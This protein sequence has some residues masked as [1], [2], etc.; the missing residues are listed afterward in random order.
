MRHAP[1]VEVSPDDRRQLRAW[2]GAEAPRGRLAV[3]AQIVLDAAEGLP[4]ARIAA[5]LGVQA[6]T[7][8]RWRSRFALNGLEGLTREAPRG[9][10]GARVPRATIQRIVRATL[11]RHPAP[12]G[13][14]TTRS[15]AHSL[16]VN[17]MLVHRVWA[18]HGLGNRAPVGARSRPRVDLAG[19]FVT[20]G[21]RAVVFVVDERPVP[22]APSQLPELY[23]NPTDRPEFTG[24]QS[25][26]VDLVQTVEMIAASPA[27]AERGPNPEAALLVFLRGLERG[28]RQ[29]SRL[30]VVFDRPLARLGR[31]VI[32]WL[33]A[34]GRFRAF[35][36]PRLAQWPRTVESW[37]RRWEPA[38]VDR[39]SF[40][41]AATFAH[42]LA[43]AVAGGRAD[44][45]AALRF[46]W[47]AGSAQRIGGM[48]TFPGSRVASRRVSTSGARRSI[49][50]RGKP[51]RR[52]AA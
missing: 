52:L 22:S 32:G 19:A 31:R 41:D 23:P 18:T 13:S 21:A 11:D 38:G 26:A 44:S 12:G 8:A 50:Y 49:R 7:A 10:A 36:A 1:R 37:L 5:R 4:N 25:H 24:P 15:L 45:L 46:S 34:H 2:A 20:P 9:G 51:A 47:R 40:G 33:G 16:R 6:E 17:H 14:W 43:P 29:C 28:I 30:E 48:V 35:T 42:E 39:A 3:R 27:L